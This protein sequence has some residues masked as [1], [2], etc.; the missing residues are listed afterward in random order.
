MTNVVRAAAALLLLVAMTATPCAAALRVG[1]A[2]V[3]SLTNSTPKLTILNN[4]MQFV[5]MASSSSA[6]L[7]VFPEFALMGNF[8]FLSCTSPSSTAAYAETVGP[9]G[10]RIEC[11][12]SLFTPLQQLGCLVP[13]KYISY[14]T[15]EQD[16]S[17]FYNTQVVTYN[18]TIVA[19]YRKFHVFYTTCFTSPTLE[20]V[21]FNISAA[22]GSAYGFGIFTC[23]DILFND[24]KVDLVKMGVKY[25]SYSSAIPVIGH[26]AV[27]LFSGLYNVTVV[28][29]NNDLG[30][31]GVVTDGKFQAACPT[32]LKNCI[33]TYDLK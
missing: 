19:R 15:V 25:F 29:A 3:T 9:A 32:S 10:T 28:S 33:A 7:L 24:P 8:D 4:A 11:L 27:A 22:D 21:T 6:E 17:S 31:G 12:A 20:L 14:N 26:D 16:G 13:D 1:A 5:K 18:R 2:Q 30:E 23:Y